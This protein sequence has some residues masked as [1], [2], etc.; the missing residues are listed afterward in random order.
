MTTPTLPLPKL[1]EMRII[2]RI[3]EMMS[4]SE[5]Q[6][7]QGR[8]IVF[9]PTM[10]FLHDAHLELVRHAQKHGE[11]VVVSIFV[12]PTQFAPQ[13]DFGAYPRDFDRDR[14]LLQK[15]SVDVLFHPSAEQIYPEGYQTYVG[16]EKLSGLLCGE[17]RAGHFRGVA[18]VVAKLFNIVRPHVAVFGEKDYQQLQIIRRMV[19]DLNF[20]IEIVGHPIVREPDGLA[21]S[22][23]NAYLSAAQRRAA[24]SLSRALAKADTLVHQGQVDAGAIVEAVRAEIEAEPLA[25]VEYVRICH[26]VTLTDVEQLRDAAV[27]ALAVR[28]GK[29]RLIDNRLLHPRKDGRNG[30]RSAGQS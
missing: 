3:D 23:R 27:V 10:G 4:W 16:V 21:M 26:P 12:N 5:D 30:G 7:G 28:I 17:Q 29:A 14:Q 9:V 8:R 22:S 15:E 1:I 25:T 20:A 2:E 6:R 24:L 13:E 11:R 19:R 18:T